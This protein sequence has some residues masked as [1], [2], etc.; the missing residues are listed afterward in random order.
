MQSGCTALADRRLDNRSVEVCFKA[1]FTLDC[2][3]M[4]RDR[5]E[6]SYCAASDAPPRARTAH[7]KVSNLQCIAFR[8][9][10]HA[11]DRA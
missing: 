2:H 3:C 4:A 10:D 11:A 9:A 5:L 8:N 7:R 6:L 1:F